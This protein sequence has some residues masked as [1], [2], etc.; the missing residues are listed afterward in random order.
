LAKIQ[1]SRGS[2]DGARE[3]CSLTP[4][5]HVVLDQLLGTNTGTL[6]LEVERLPVALVRALLEDGRLKPNQRAALALR[7]HGMRSEDLEVEGVYGL[8][9]SQPAEFGS[10]LNAMT[11]LRPNAELDWNGRWYPVIVLAE[12]REDEHKLA[13]NVLVHVVLGL[14]P[15]THD[16]W[17][18]VDPGIFVDDSGDPR[19]LTVLE[20]LERLGFRRLQTP[21]QEHNLRLVN[22]ERLGSCHGTQ[23]WVKGAVLDMARRFF[24][25]SDLA[26]LPL[27]TKEM[28]RRAIVEPVLEATDP[29]HGHY[30]NRPFRNTFD[31]SAS[32]LPLVRVFS[33]DTKSY[34]FADIDDLSA[35]E[36]DET[37]LSRLYLPPE[38]KS[39]LQ[40]V[41]ETPTDQLFGDLI[42][43][44]HG[45]VVILASGSPGVGKT[46]TAEVYAEMTGRPLYV[47][48][49]GE[50]GTTVKEVEENLEHVFARVVRWRAVLQFDECEI[51]LS[52]RGNDLERSAIVGIFLR[53]LDYYEGLLF[54]TTNRADVL[55]YAIRSRVMLRLE[56][57]DLDAPARAHIW[58]TMFAAA[59]LALT[60]G[61]F[62]E[63]AQPE[64]NGRQIRN[65][66]R[67]ARI[68]HPERQLTAARVMDL[69]RYGCR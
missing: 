1:I 59:G 45:G 60:G 15:I 37:A 51:F 4:D 38:M 14:G 8:R 39:I 68:L 28:P 27:G 18:P 25:A 64:T 54:L 66:V 34:V 33:L 2:V 10:T 24:F 26:E 22:A 12:L 13:K 30:Y 65:L 3:R 47:L 21:P 19:E 62:M 6:T 49:F 43:G 63:L 11:R 9:V 36:Y 44:K 32:R 58:Q 69:L 23:V 57:P 52:H 48:E 40:R 35:Y 55:D 42:R 31:R 67:L 53:M 20:V 16:L 61:S 41:F 5:E 7:V 50:L 46:L 56:Y 29:E 17:R